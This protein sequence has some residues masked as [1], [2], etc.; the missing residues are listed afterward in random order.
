[1]L[2]YSNS[3]YRITQHHPRTHR[4]LRVAS[5]NL[6][7]ILHE[8][9]RLMNSKRSLIPASDA[10]ACAFVTRM[11][12]CASHA[13]DTD[14]SHCQNSTGGL[15]WCSKMVAIGAAVDGV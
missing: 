6:L 11:A 5:P 4:K 1:M 10:F 15:R 8:I 3:S 9:R 13:P 12:S 14:R 2:G 7:T